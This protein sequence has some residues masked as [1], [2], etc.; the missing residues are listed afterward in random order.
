MPTKK[1]GSP[2]SLGWGLRLREADE[3]QS[4]LRGSL[5]Q[6]LAAFWREVLVGDRHVLLPDLDGLLQK[7]GG[8]LQTK[9]VFQT[10]RHQHHTSPQGRRPS[11]LRSRMREGWKDEGS[12][13][14]CSPDMFTL[15]YWGGKSPRPTSFCK[16][17]EHPPS[18]KNNSY[19]DLK[20]G[21]ANR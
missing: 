20:E 6:D 13:V 1:L 17:G 19:F 12:P 10:C 4:H 9:R 15:W 8:C 3:S 5:S 14:K 11:R 21:R 18:S 7:L 16:S 2:R